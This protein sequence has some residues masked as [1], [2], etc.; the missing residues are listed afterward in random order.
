MNILNI[1]P[2]LASFCIGFGILIPVIALLKTS[3]IKNIEIK[4]LFILMA[5]KTVRIVGILY[6]ILWFLNAYFLQKP[7]EVSEGVSLMKQDIFG[8]YW[9]MYWFSPIMYLLLTQLFWL[10][11][12]VTKRAALITISL[13]LLVLPSQ[14][15]LLMVTSGLK[16]AYAS[17]GIGVIFIQAALGMIIFFFTTFLLLTLSGK[18]KKFAK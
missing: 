11:K 10:K 16:S 7:V 2:V 6:V 1:V 15:L 8:P 12:M 9:A 18:L 13:L 5:V 14:R 3:D 4:N 17:G